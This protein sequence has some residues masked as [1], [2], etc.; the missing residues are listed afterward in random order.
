[1]PLAMKLM[2]FRYEGICGFAHDAVLHPHDAGAP[3]IVGSLNGERFL[4]TDS[5]GSVRDQRGHLCFVSFTTQPQGFVCRVCARRQAAC[6][7]TD[8]S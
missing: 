8:Q 7:S 6:R 2:I 4:Y 5:L 3:L 1:M